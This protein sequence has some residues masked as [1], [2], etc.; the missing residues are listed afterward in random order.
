MTITKNDILTG[1]EYAQVVEATLGKITSLQ[2]LQIRTRY[3][4]GLT[5]IQGN[6]ELSL[7]LVGKYLTGRPWDEIEAMTT[8]DL[9]AAI[10]TAWRAE[11]HDADKSVD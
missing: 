6:P 7:L 4:A 2:W 10:T 3:D 11:D 8:S 1:E 5:D 9:M